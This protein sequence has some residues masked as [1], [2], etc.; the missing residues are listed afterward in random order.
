MYM[1]IRKVVNVIGLRPFGLRII[2]C[3]FVFKIAVAVVYNLIS[4]DIDRSRMKQ[5]KVY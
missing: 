2:A 3:R 5:L 1:Y 4:D